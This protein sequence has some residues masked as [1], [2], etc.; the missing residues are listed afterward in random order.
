M[1]KLLV[2]PCIPGIG[3]LYN[4]KLAIFTKVWATK[5]PVMGECDRNY[6]I[7]QYSLIPNLQ[8]YQIIE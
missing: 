2:S 5:L 4:L 7:L 6:N 1:Q 8:Q 3:T